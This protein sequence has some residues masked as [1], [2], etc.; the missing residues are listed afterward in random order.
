[1]V[2][3]LEGYNVTIHK[4]LACTVQVEISPSPFKGGRLSENL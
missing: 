4:T 2:R 1:M 3:V